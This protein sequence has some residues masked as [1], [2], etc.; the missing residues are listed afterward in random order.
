MIELTIRPH[1]WDL[2]LFLHVGGALCAVAALVAGFC[3]LVVAWRSAGDVRVGL[4][5]FGF[6]TLLY[7]G[8]PSFLVMRVCAEWV[9]SREHLGSSTA[10]W[11]SDYAYPFTDG[12]FA[13][14]LIATILAGF[15]ARRQRGGG[16]FGLTAAATVLTGIAVVSLGV[17]IWAMTTKPI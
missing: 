4:S 16:G 10:A 11:L 13:V 9:V 12:A 17:V 14:L 8:I 6:R 3:V 2:P 15:G 1:S 7:A 5:R